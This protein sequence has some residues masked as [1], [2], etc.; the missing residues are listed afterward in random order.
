[1]KCKQHAE[2]F[3]WHAENLLHAFPPAFPEETVEQ[4]GLRQEACK[5]C[6]TALSQHLEVSIHAIYG[7]HAAECS[8]TTLSLLFLQAVLEQTNYATFQ[9]LLQFAATA[10][11]DPNSS[12]SFAQRRRIIPTALTFA[13]GVNSADHA[14]TFPTLV[15]LLR[16]QVRLTHA[17]IQASAMCWCTERG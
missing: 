12:N 10:H 13:G 16:Q 8:I 7:K 6:W 5:T 15:S 4:Q 1:M 3:C 17:W 14:Q 2:G 9:A 11:Q